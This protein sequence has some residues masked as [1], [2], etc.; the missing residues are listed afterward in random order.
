MTSAFPELVKSVL[1]RP[2]VRSD[3]AERVGKFLQSAVRLIAHFIGSNDHPQLLETLSFLFDWQGQYFYRL[4]GSSQQAA[5]DTEQDTDMELCSALQPS[6]IKKK[7]P[8]LSP[9]ARRNIEL[10]AELKG[11]DRVRARLCGEEPMPPYHIV[12]VLIRPIVLVR[13]LFDREF[14]ASFAPAL[15]TSITGH[16]CAM[17]EAQLKAADKGDVD[18]V[19]SDLEYLLREH[20]NTVA[21][22]EFFDRFRLEF[23]H[24]NLS[25]NSL[26]NRLAGLADVKKLCELATEKGSLE[27]QAQNPP[28]SPSSSSSSS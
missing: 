4:F 1:K 14:L 25:S 21:T 11:F 9:Y 26:K 20:Q 6:Y 27:S 17:S 2:D 24:L 8:H 5:A 18:T 19:V 3:Q 15:C 28:P 10:F 23:A 16:I 22:S 7:V 12:R 13:E